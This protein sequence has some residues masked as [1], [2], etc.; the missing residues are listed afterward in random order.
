V[1]FA[2]ISDRDTFSSFANQNFSSAEKFNNFKDSFDDEVVLSIVRNPQLR[3]NRKLA[4]QLAMLK[5][6]KNSG[7]TISRRL[8]G[9]AKA[10]KISKG[11]NNTLKTEGCD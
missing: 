11:E 10:E 7:L 2:D 9:A 3:N 1:L 5:L 8:L 4:G 6:L